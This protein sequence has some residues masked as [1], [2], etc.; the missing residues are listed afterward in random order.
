ASAGVTVQPIIGGAVNATVGPLP[1][2]SG[3]APPAYSQNGTV[4]SLGLSTSL[5]GG[6][7]STGVINTHV[8]GQSGAT[9][10]AVAES[11]VNGVGIAL[12]VLL[13]LTADTVQATAS[14][15]VVNGVVTPHGSTLITNPHIS[16]TL[17]TGLSISASPTPNTVLLN[18]LGIRLVL[19]EQVIT[20]TASSAA[21]EVNA[22]HLSISNTLLNLIGNI[23]GD[24]VI[25]HTEASLSGVGANVTVSQTASP[26]TVNTGGQTTYSIVISNA[27]PLTANV[28]SVSEALPASFTLVSTSFTGPF[29]IAPGGSQTIT[30]TAQAGNTVGTFLANATVT[31]SNFPT[32]STGPSAPVT[33]VA[34]VVNGTVDGTVHDRVTGAVIPGATVVLRDGNGQVVGTTT[35]D[36]NG[37]YTLPN[38]PPGSYTATFSAPGYSPQTQP[39]TLTSGGT[40]HVDG[41]LAPLPGTIQGTVT[42]GQTGQPLPGAT[43]TITYN[44]TTV[45]T[46]TDSNGHYNF[47]NV[48]SEVPVT[49]TISHPD[50]GTQPP[51]TV[52]LPPGGNDTRTT[53]LTPLPGTI[54]GTILDGGTSQPLA[55]AT[56]VL[57]D[58]NGQVVGTTTTD[59]SG[60]YTFPNLPPGNY[61]IEMSAPGYQTSTVSQ[62]VGPN[63]TVTRSDSLTPNPGTVNGTVTDALTGAPLAGATVTITQNGNTLTTTT[64]ANGRY[65]LTGVVPNVP[66]TITASAP[67]YQSSTPS[68]VTVPAG[69]S[70]TRDI[71]LQ[72]LPGSI[73]GTVSNASNGAPISGAVVE[74][75]RDGVVVATTTTDA[76][77]HYTF[78]GVTPGNYS[79]RFS[80]TGFGT[81]TLPATV[82]PN[83]P[84]TLNASLTPNPPPNTD[85][86]LG[87]TV[88]N[89]AN[90]T[91][92]SGALVELISNGNVVASTSTNASGQYSFPTV[93]QGS[94]SVRFSA[95]GFNTATLATTITAN[96]AQTLN[97]ALTASGGGN[98]PTTG[99]LSGTVTNAANG[100]PIAGALVELISNGNVVATTSTNAS[101]QYGFAAVQQG[102]YA[103]R[104]SATGFNTAM[105]ATTITAGQAQT[106]NAALTASGGGNPPTTGSL[107][108]AVTDASNGNPI[109]GALVELISNGNVI[110]TTSTNASGQYGFANIEAGGYTVR[111]S[112]TGY[113]TATMATTIIAGQTQT[114]NA[115]LARQVTP[116]SDTNGT[117]SGSITDAANGTPIAGATV[118][119]TENG[120]PRTTTTDASGHYSFSN[121]KTGSPVQVSASAADYQSQSSAPVTLPTDG[122]ATIN[123]ALQPLPGTISGTVTGSGNAP[124]AGVQ[125][126]LVDD[127]GHVIA[128]TTTDASGHYSFSNIVPGNYTLRFTRD[129]YVPATES[130]IVPRN[131]TVVVNA[132]LAPVAGSVSGR[133]LD[134]TTNQPLAGATVTLVSGS[135]T[136]TTTTNSAGQYVFANVDANVPSTLRATRADYFDGAPVSF[137]LTPGGSLN[138]DLTLQPRPGS[139]GGHVTAT[140]GGALAGVSITLS[141]AS[142]TPIGTTTTDAS[143]NYAFDSLPPGQYALHFSKAGYDNATASAAVSANQRT[144][145]DQV[146]STASVTP[147]PTSISG[148][149]KDAHSGN[150]IPGAVVTLTQNGAVRTT[151]SDANGEY[152]FS[153]VTPNVSATL[154]ASSDD[155]QPL[156]TAPFTPTSGSAERHD[157]SLLPKPGSL[158]GIV[159]DAANNNPLANVLVE[160][161]DEDNNLIASTHTDS[162]GVYRFASIAAG[163]YRVFFSLT[164]YKN[165]VALAD[166]APNRHSI[167]DMKLVSNNGG[168]TD[169]GGDGNSC[170]NNAP[171]L[172]VPQS[173]AVGVSDTIRFLVGAGDTEPVTV[174]A[175]NLP[176]CATFD[177]ATGLFVL[178]GSAACWNGLDEQVLTF[179]AKD[180]LGAISSSTVTISIGASETVGR[181]RSI[182]ADAHAAQ[183]RISRPSRPVVAEVGELMEIPIMA[184]TDNPNCSVDL[185]ITAPASTSYNADR[186][187]LTWAPQLSE[188]G[189]VAS[190]TIKGTD[191][192]GVVATAQ[193][194]LI[195]RGGADGGKLAIP[196]VELQFG[197][198][199]VGTLSKPIALV[200]RNI[201]TSDLQ[202]NSFKTDSDR[203]L[204]DGLLGLP[205]VIP[206]G[207]EVQ[208]GLR[209]APNAIGPTTATL[210]AE[211]TDP[212]EPN[213]S[214]KLDGEGIVQSNSVSS[215]AQDLV[216][217]VPE[218]Q[219][220][221]RGETLRFAVSAYDRRGLAVTIAPDQLPD[222]SSYDNGIV[223]FTPMDICSADS[224]Q[225]VASFTA[226]SSDGT[227]ESAS[228]TIHLVAHA[229]N[230]NDRAPIVSAPSDLV[231]VSPGATLSVPVRAVAQTDGCSVTMTSDATGFI[232]FNG[233]TGTV[234][235][236]PTA[237]D[238][239][240]IGTVMI[241]AT[242]CQGRSSRDAF[243][244]AVTDSG[245]VARGEGLNVPQAILLRPQPAG[246]ALIVPLSNEDDVPHRVSSVRMENGSSILLDQSIRVPFTLNP[247]QVLPLHLE[248]VGNQPLTDR[249]VVTTND[250]GAQAVV[251]TIGSR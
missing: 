243:E 62:T 86:S 101:G 52:T 78:N 47:P 168:T 99:S 181:R 230:T 167:V 10:R 82:S 104:F 238:L 28:T 174:R 231:L 133:V 219:V 44:G 137:T 119:L 170:L 132:Q 209:F 75:I 244:Y 189:S 138:Q 224:T 38:I 250:S 249:L 73:G 54:N 3:T 107:G 122:S 36:A 159:S 63:Q 59:S 126:Q 60:H 222:G 120:T 27:G 79:V 173:I 90:G 56:V 182:G 246:G 4:A 51:Y 140:D 207:R 102:G 94:Y 149:V 76:S 190:V 242:D 35:A 175:L 74:L 29:S 18:L 197:P 39:V 235:F 165:G 131:G 84:L 64:D 49:V 2:S 147:Q 114:V 237:S 154:S 227:M 184:D 53:G 199:P 105:D 116:P 12:P 8:E 216:I 37:H 1:I 113:I 239:G 66:A 5:T 20:Q 30:V 118:T 155:Y 13:S 67:N 127:Q 202:I 150:P 217:L 220:V 97:A 158:G 6:I 46:T 70:A 23:S 214:V 95:T 191:C 193:F 169:P 152:S 72:P 144:T 115:A 228:V 9:P 111:F 177:P 248:V 180:S 123:L 128:T 22:I 92:I 71:T 215:T 172:S 33:V 226:V 121:V 194:W 11:T 221:E 229:G 96:Q 87:G 247:G 24:I 178:T 223:S 251:T 203:F 188:A 77:G 88:T 164:G 163:S 139:I 171:V 65:S 146:L 15:D 91:P 195:V 179:E 109:N 61:T 241:T 17:G 100:N 83:Q 89:A 125:V 236:T 108:G 45:T 57:R 112:A 14:V 98:P 232:G 210:T 129:G 166:V 110:A 16:G 48:P 7:L 218:E 136:R 151:T 208:V 21:I 42:N 148:V 141:N 245:F 211:T 206:T 135:T 58:G 187:I 25:G 225:Y 153:D 192:R 204:V 143:G 198:V 55:G 186:G 234:T 40:A 50:Y 156:T 183:V 68:T 160:V 93:Q 34:P 106:L 69:G 176:D 185:D 130:A 157:L 81:S 32:A 196:P 80:A 233:S 31:G 142:G 19:N 213:I 124:L 212:D 162:L 201:G 134:A 145:V 85:G 103:V 43:V 41:S 200:L 117:I 205:L 161:R 26:S 240:K